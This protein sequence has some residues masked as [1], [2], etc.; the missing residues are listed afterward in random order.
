MKKEILFLIGIVFLTLIHIDLR[1]QEIII[2][3]TVSNQEGLPLS[4]VTIVTLDQLYAI[5]NE[6]GSFNLR[7]PDNY[8]KVSLS[9]SRLGCV[10]IDTTII[11]DKE[12][13][14]IDIIL[15]E[16][17]YELDPVSINSDYFNILEEPNRIVIDFTII[18]NQFIF[19]YKEKGNQKLGLFTLEGDM[20]H[21]QIIP[22]YYNFKQI[23]ISCTK[24]IL[25]IGRLE[26]KEYFLND[27]QLVLLNSFSKRKYDELLLPCIA[28]LGNTLYFKTY[29]E[30]N[31]IVNYSTSTNQQKLNSIITITD[32][33][34]LKVAQEFYH[35]I[36]IAYTDA[37]RNN[38]TLPNQR[39]NHY[40]YVTGDDIFNPHII[41]DNLWDG[42]MLKL[43]VDKRTDALVRQ[44][45]HLESSPIQVEEFIK[46]SLLYIINHIDENLLQFNPKTNLLKKLSLDGLLWNEKY[47][48]IQ[49]EA[50]KLTYLINSS[51]LG[52]VTIDLILIDGLACKLKNIM[53][54]PIIREKKG[55]VLI[56]KDIFYYITH[57]GR[58]RSIKLG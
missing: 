30:H 1:A 27:M 41:N 46:D 29:K 45:L 5:S 10:P 55:T 12:F 9:I 53:T 52:K 40:D 3:G 17:I 21:E 51:P 23:I 57:G 19:L 25:V 2:R 36:L 38:Y 11:L 37:V 56:H 33:V 44:Y 50:T 34:A 49:D 54:L 14:S 6:N 32:S 28:K 39:K 35:D 47:L 15:Q 8:S 24:T 18:N 43:M 20:I 26:C 31:K 48:P 13:V 58:F 42:N 7:I 22:S 16:K 4:D